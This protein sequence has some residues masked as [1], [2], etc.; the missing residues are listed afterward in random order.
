MFAI[1]VF[2]AEKLFTC[3]SDLVSKTEI[4]KHLLSFNII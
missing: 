3:F 1:M 4:M 2:V